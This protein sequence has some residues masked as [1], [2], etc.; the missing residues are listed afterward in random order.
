MLPEE[1]LAFIAKIGLV[2]LGLL[3]FSKFIL[4]SIYYVQEEM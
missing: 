2:V 4:M 1:Q 3:Y